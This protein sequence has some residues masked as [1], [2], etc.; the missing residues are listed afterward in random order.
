MKT[1]IAIA[2]IAAVS[3][4]GWGTVRVVKA[5]S[6]TQ[7]CSGYLERAGN[8]N[9]IE[10]AEREL[11]VAIGHLDR[12]GIKNGYTSVLWR[13]PD[14]DVGFW[15]DNLSASLGE[16][17]EINEDASMLE[18]SNVLM[19]LRETLTDGGKS[20]TQLTLP[21]GISIYPSNAAFFWWGWVSF[22]VAGIFLGVAWLSK[23]A[24]FSLRLG[25]PSPTPKL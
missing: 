16:L 8:A 4:L 23:M 17:R 9:T 2:I 5:V 24:G 10:L 25:Q 19:K 15:Y 14:E 22:G 1:L 11:A 20:G 6:F 21:P 3:F 12:S 18:R 7:Q 13:T